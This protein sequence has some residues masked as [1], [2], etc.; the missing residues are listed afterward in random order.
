MRNR[1][2]S[3]VAFAKDDE[4]LYAHRPHPQKEAKPYAVSNVRA[5]L[6]SIGV[7]P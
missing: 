6:E 2:G 7:T 5:F 4:V 3:K 1:G